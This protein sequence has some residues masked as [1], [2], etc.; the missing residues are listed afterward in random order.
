MLCFHNTQIT[1]P[2]SGS[3]DRATSRAE[4]GEPTAVCERLRRLSGD[5]LE[6]KFQAGEM[7]GSHLRRWCPPS[8]V[9]WFQIPWKLVRYITNKKLTYWTYKPP[10][11]CLLVYRLVYNPINYRYQLQFH[12]GL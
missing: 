1:Q 5:W 3:S 4:R 7:F 6:V 11:L 12:Y 10:K 2:W 8:Y 9:G